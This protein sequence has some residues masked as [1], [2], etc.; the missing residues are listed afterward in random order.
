MISFDV[1][2][3]NHEQA[4]STD[5]ACTNWAEGS[6]S[7]MRR[8]EAGH[9]HHI[10]G[11]YLI[12]YAQGASFREDRRRQDNGGQF[13]RVVELVGANGPS[14]DFCGYWQRSRKVA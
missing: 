12:S 5:G 11:A 13:A 14:V 1:R 8:G 10:S 2:R 4:Y 6:F 3:I 9:H 7:R